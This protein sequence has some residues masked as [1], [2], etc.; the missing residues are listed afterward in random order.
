MDE[1]EV[2]A[3]EIVDG[4]IVEGDPAEGE[5]VAPP[6]WLT[7]TE[8]D[9]LAAPKSADGGVAQEPAPPPATE[10]VRSA[11][12]SEGALPADIEIDIALTIEESQ[13]IDDVDD[14]DTEEPAGV[15]FGGALGDE[16]GVNLDDI[17]LNDDGFDDVDLDDLAIGLERP[18]EPQ[19]DLED[20]PA[21][22]DPVGDGGALPLDIDIEDPSGDIE[23]VIRQSA[24]APSAPENEFDLW[25]ASLAGDWKAEPRQAEDRVQSVRALL[26]E[27]GVTPQTDDVR[28]SELYRDAVSLEEGPQQDE[29][30][31]GAPAPREPT[32][33]DSVPS[34]VSKSSVLLAP[35]PVE[36]TEI[37]ADGED[38]SL[39]PELESSIS[40]LR[41]L[42]MARREHLDLLD[43]K[44]AG[45]PV[46]VVLTDN[47]DVRV[48]K[49]GWILGDEEGASPLDQLPEVEIDEADI[50]IALELDDEDVTYIFDEGDLPRTGAMDMAQ[51]P[52]L[53]TTKIQ[54]P[55]PA[56]IDPLTGPY[57]AEQDDG[58]GL[59]GTPLLGVIPSMP[60]LSGGQFPDGSLALA[61]EQVAPHTPVLPDRPLDDVS[62]KLEG[63]KKDFVEF[64]KGEA[65]I[66]T[67]AARVGRALHGLGH[68]V[69]SATE[70]GDTASRLFAAACASDPG[71]VISDW[72]LT[73]QLEN[74][75]QTGQLLEHLLADRSATS[76]RQHFAG[77]VARRGDGD[78]LALW[79]YCSDKNLAAGLAQFITALG[80]Y[81]WESAY[82]AM[83]RLREMPSAGALQGVFALERARLAEETQDQFPTAPDYLLA[84]DEA[85]A[86]AGPSARAELRGI[87]AGNSALLVRALQRI[88]ASPKSD[89]VRRVTLA[90]LALAHNRAGHFAEALATYE[91]LLKMAPND[92]DALRQASLLARRMGKV[93]THR[94][95]MARLA[96]TATDPREAALRHYENG[97]F[98]QRYSEDE[99]GAE[100]AFR[101]ALSALPTFTP[102]LARLSRIS[103]IQGR[104]EEINRRYIAEIQQL[105]KVLE[106]DL[107]PEERGRIIGGL[108]QRY[109]RLALAF[110]RD[111]KGTRA[112][113]LH[114]R[115]L[116]LQPDA[117]PSLVTLE[118]LFR[119][120][121]E[122]SQ[123]VSLLLGWSLRT[124]SGSKA[125]VEPLLQAADVSRCYLDDREA[126]GQLLA[127]VL[128]IA[129]NHPYA[130]QRAQ[131][132]FARSGRVGA[133]IEVLERMAA[134]TGA[135]HH[136]LRIASLQSVEIASP[137]HARSALD[138]YSNLLEQDGTNPSAIEGAVRA[139]WSL[140]RS[141]ASLQSADIQALVGAGEPQA[142]LCAVDAL[143]AER[144]DEEAAQLLAM[145]RARR[146]AEG[147][148]NPEA[149]QSTLTVLVVVLER[150]SDWPALVDALE[151]LAVM[152]EGPEQGAILARLGEIWEIRLGDLPMAED[153]YQR[154]LRADATNA[155]ASHGLDRITPKAPDGLRPDFVFGDSIS[156]IRTAA[157]RRDR[158]DVGNRLL[159]FAAKMEDQPQKSAT[160][161]VAAHLAGVY[162]EL[163]AA[164]EAA[165]GNVS[166]FETLRGQLEERG[167]AE[168]LIRIIEAHL[169]VC[170][171]GRRLDLLGTLIGL[172][173]RTGDIGGARATAE[174][175]LDLDADSMLARLI[176]RRTASAH[177]APDYAEAQ[178]AAL[179]DAFRS[180]EA[181]AQ[182]HHAR[183]LERTDAAGDEL[184]AKGVRL[185]PQN[186][187]LARTFEARLEAKAQHPELD[188]LYEYRLKVVEDP[189]ERLRIARRRA[190]LLADQFSETGLALQ[191][192][193]SEL[194][195]TKPDPEDLLMAARFCQT[196]GY[197]ER[198]DNYFE[199]AEVGM[200]PDAAGPNRAI[201]VAHATA[202]LERGDLAEAGK[203]L[204]GVLD[205]TSADREALLLLGEIAAKTRDWRDVIK[206]KRRLIAYEDDPNIQAQHATGIGEIFSRVYQDN[207][208]ALGWF[209]R[210]VEVAPLEQSS[211]RRMV[212]E[213]GITEVSDN[214]KRQAEA[215]LANAATARTQAFVD[216]GG[217][218]DH[219]VALYELRGF[220]G[221]ELG[222]LR[223]AQVMSWFG[224]SSPEMKATLEKH[225]GRFTLR[226]PLD[227]DARS[228]FVDSGGSANR[229]GALYDA[230]YQVLVE[231]L[232]KPIPAG[233]PRLSRRS[234]RD[235][236]TAYQEL[237]VQLGVPVA[238]LWNGGRSL[239]APWATY[240]PHPAIAIPIHMFE[241]GL[242]GAHRFILAQTL[243]GLRRG[244]HLLQEAGS[245]SAAETLHR[246]CD[247]LRS[248][249]GDEGQLRGTRGYRLLE[250]A[251]RLPRPKRLRLEG[252][253]E[254]VAE[255]R[256]GL[257]TLEEATKRAMDRAGLLVAGDIHLALDVVLF[258]RPDRSRDAQQ[259]GGRFPA[260]ANSSRAQALVSFYVG[261][262]YGDLCRFDQREAVRAGAE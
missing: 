100:A 246:L 219:L 168:G 57:T 186:A 40:L 131:D 242:V 33:S 38:G 225:T 12:P 227:N 25:D 24:S 113:E 241:E 125:T 206:I 196:L 154:S 78:S 185:D 212:A 97:V 89:D 158:A 102:A 49:V 50:E 139:L 127:R 189:E 250:R 176:L 145:W 135:P 108:V 3:G 237:A 210:S 190:L 184:L 109:Y 166:I 134:R 140:D 191:V 5:I 262:G 118:A 256:Q 126:G 182:L 160:L 201:T 96:E 71:L 172:R 143:L 92:R 144:S 155:A 159:D 41:Q 255:I 259:V 45:V 1:T 73:C 58:D 209:C 56:A 111:D 77:H 235:W 258:G 85:E 64:L 62:L 152:L 243:E 29:A 234:F 6:E 228:R 48:E 199:Q 47:K 26:E 194:E 153:C 107:V 68:T 173:M 76:G 254:T 106:H 72:A 31:T 105:E 244:R 63:L 174:A 257:V 214:R 8:S 132:H 233:V 157:L 116:A 226:R 104:H 82:A 208:R 75:G 22:G 245:Q 99:A 171:A 216:E 236:Q 37:S 66:G 60:S 180:P 103:R 119:E 67:E 253:A 23:T 27:G 9:R 10:A 213:L 65:Y 20:L 149:S 229:I 39:D 81:N 141:L 18:P 164:F 223:I 138:T 79:Q 169:D 181:T 70:A 114:K 61:A 217:I 123:L 162:G 59:M 36:L 137:T 204:R 218:L 4:E 32:P 232:A 53:G 197:P 83:E 69:A 87:E 151:E 42:S 7:E 19:A 175:V 150:L 195:K 165:P 146:L 124:R 200:S 136:Y 247:L 251:K 205:G 55:S 177:E 30:D 101:A 14:A 252:A 51:S 202:L 15:D 207:E 88:I 142:V 178:S 249:E 230:G 54:R 52:Y 130:L 93:R 90:K 120:S 193:E 231:E 215:V 80:Q 44:G 179:L 128:N 224:R 133:L 112:A 211:V 222:M 122:W 86:P 238:E 220:Q 74:E 117:T 13:S 43:G 147:D 110:S 161:K 95:M 188:A 94:A 167:D 98:L 16:E 148:L 221:D 156:Q 240:L 17:D 129:P 2:Y 248:S 261:E 46:E 91:A 34:Q 163:A 28:I 35:A 170:D 11:L 239:D 115:A 187:E 260:Y 183:A 121:G 198:A 21:I 203:R 84:L 192:L